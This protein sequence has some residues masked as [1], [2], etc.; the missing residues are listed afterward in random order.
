MNTQ[1]YNPEMDWINSTNILLLLLE[2]WVKNKVSDFLDSGT[3][4]ELVGKMKNIPIKDKS[5][6]F[7]E[8]KNTDFENIKI[9]KSKIDSKYYLIDINNDINFDIW[10]IEIVE[11]INIGWKIV[12]QAKDYDIDWY[13]SYYDYNTWK[14]ISKKSD[15]KYNLINDA[16][17]L[18]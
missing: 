15:K 7:S 1:S 9:W 10:F 2:E 14:I 8:V 12:F 18:Y 5:L 11:V 16:T 4:T 13:Y 6:Y 3:I 17:L